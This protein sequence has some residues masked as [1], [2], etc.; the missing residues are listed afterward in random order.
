VVYGLLSTKA[1]AQPAG[2]AATQNQNHKS[3]M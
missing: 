3:G 1:A 2:I